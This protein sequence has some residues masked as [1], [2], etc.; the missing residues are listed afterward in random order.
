M[1][2][3]IDSADIEDVRR[4]FELG[5]VTGVTTNPALIAKTGRPGVEVLNDLLD[6]TNGP[7]FYQVTASTL[8]G[9]MEQAREAARLAPRR[10]QVKLGATTENISLAAHLS[11]EGIMCCVTAVASPA[12]AYL[13][14]LS[15]A[16]YVAPYVNRLS[17]QLGDGVAVVRQCVEVM[18]GSPTRLLAASLKSVDEM[19]AV[20]LAGAHDITIPL[21][22]ILKLGDDELSDKA[23]E[24]FAAAMQ[25][26][27]AANAPQ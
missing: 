17:R 27:S 13:A 21:E 23:I 4:A 1:A 14:A 24:E 15:G 19:L 2:L 6:L 12:Q 22:L 16:T 3:F 11:R 20:V 18:K 26:Q 7:V 10:V 8:A 25:D 5:F 9:R